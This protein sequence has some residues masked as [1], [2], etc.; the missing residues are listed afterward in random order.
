MTAVWPGPPLKVAPHA[1]AE[2]EE[3]VVDLDD[4]EQR[5]EDDEQEH[6]IG[7]DGEELAEDA[8]QSDAEI[9]D[10]ERVLELLVARAVRRGDG[11]KR[12]RAMNRPATDRQDW[13]PASTRAFHHYR[14]ED[15]A[16]DDAGRAR[17]TDRL[18]EILDIEVDVADR[19][20]RHRDQREIGEPAGE[21]RG[22]D[23]AVEEDQHENER[24][25]DRLILDK[26]RENGLRAGHVV[27]EHGETASDER[28]TRDPVEGHQTG[29]FP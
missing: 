22:A 5:A 23:G 21:G 20:E 3:Q 10:D 16:D 4:R 25:M 11:R 18:L 2:F 19:G 24:E 13:S 7:R 15:G 14:D 8:G 9:G 12:S 17:E 6:L 27:A 28:E 29:F 26:A 1:L